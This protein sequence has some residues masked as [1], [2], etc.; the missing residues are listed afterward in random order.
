MFFS[1]YV[2][3]K[4]D[5]ENIIRLFY[6]VGVINERSKYT[7]LITILFL[8][9]SYI[10]ILLKDTLLIRGNNESDGGIYSCQARN[11]VGKSAVLETHVVIAG[12][13]IFITRPPPELR[14][15]EGDP[16]NVTCRGFGDPV[17]IVYWTHL[18]KSRPQAAII[19]RVDCAGDE[20]MALYWKPGFNGSYPQTFV[21]HYSSE[22]SPS[23]DRSLLTASNFA[24]IRDLKAFT[25][26]RIHI[27]SRNER[28][29]MNSS[30]VEKY[31]CSTLSAP[32]NVRFSGEFELRWDPVPYAQSYKVESKPDNISS[33]EEIGEIIDPVYRIRPEFQQNRLFRVRSLRASY[34]P[35]IA[36]KSI[37]LD[38]YGTV[39]S[40]KSIGDNQYN[41][42][43]IRNNTAVFVV[44]RSR[45]IL[46]YLYIR[47]PVFF[48][49]IWKSTSSNVDR[50]DDNQW[51]DSVKKSIMQTKSQNDFDYCFPGESTNAVDDMLKEKYVMTV[52]DIPVQLMNDLR[53]ERLRREFKQFHS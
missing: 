47:D 12:P 10:I 42:K 45:R 30:A 4:Y 15:H 46:A 23:D 51:N 21:V 14:V 1:D 50:S 24:T 43:F 31:V 5:F 2:V 27:E 16:V 6:A 29:S 40:K 13:P 18:K 49:Q 32:M 37:S 33:F 20:S 34:E 22:E 25:K 8:C 38:S 19:E 53:I 28:G 26:Y 52:Q 44:G 11:S 41:L 3:R 17:P 35:S 7:Y 39:S 36:S 48:F 9:D